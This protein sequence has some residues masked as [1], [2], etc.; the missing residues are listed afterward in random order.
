MPAAKCDNAPVVRGV[1]LDQSTENGSEFRP[2]ADLHAVAA[3]LRQV[4][5]L[6]DA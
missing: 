6:R 4:G 2:C 3:F 1:C 5:G